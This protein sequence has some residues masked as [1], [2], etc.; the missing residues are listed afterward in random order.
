[1]SRHDKECFQGILHG[2]NIIEEDAESVLTDEEDEAMDEFFR[3]I[4]ALASKIRLLALDVDGVLT[5]GTIF[6][7]A[8]GEIFKGFNAK[9]G[10]GI[11]CALRSGIEVAII[12]GRHSEIVHRR[13]EELG[14]KFVLEGIRDKGEALS[15]LC[16]KLK[17]SLNEVAYIGDDLNDLPA[18]SRCGFSLAP[19]DAVCSV[20][21]KA[22]WNLLADGGHGAVREAVELILTAQ[23]KWE[24]I[25]E[26]YYDAGQGD[27]Q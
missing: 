7:A 10:M 8:D 9:D 24:D 13:A 3:Y 12:T 2:R 1:M 14:I 19:N 4:D 27:R 16:R 25:A 18:F 20:S 6:I 26:S 23:G 17:I 5:D 15:E 22:D 11:S 21:E